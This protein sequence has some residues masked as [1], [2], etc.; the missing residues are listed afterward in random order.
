[1]NALLKKGVHVVSVNEYLVERDARFCAECLNPLNI[2]VGYNLASFDAG[3]KKEMFACDITY[4]TNSELGFDYLRDNMVRNYED[5]VIRGLTYAICDEGDSILIDEAR[6]P[7]IISGQ[8]KQNVS[9]YIEVDRFAKTLVKEDYKRDYETNSISL[10]DTGVIKA[11]N[12]FK[13]D[14]IYNIE[15]SDIVHKIKNALM[16]NY[17][18][19]AEVEY[20]VREDEILLIDQ[21]TGRIMEGRSYNAGL[22]QAIQAKEYVKIE[23]E[24]VIVATITYQSLFRL[25]KKLSACSGT[26]FTESEE[27]LKTYNMVVVNVPTNKPIVR[28]DLNDFVFDN[29]YSK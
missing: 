12:Y 13:F 25:Y 11:Q 27:F 15:N 26:A 22:Q 1:L 29:K 9:M 6:T 24:N 20:I 3:T 17:V 28:K 2:T 4:T 14:N 18:F 5:K 19:Q 7:L 21:F 16:A 23:P 8:P 10:S